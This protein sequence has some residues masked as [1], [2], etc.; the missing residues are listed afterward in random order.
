MKKYLLSIICTLLPI[1][2]SGADG[3]VLTATVDGIE[4][5]YKVLSESERTCQIGTSNFDDGPAI[6]RTTEGVV[7]IPSSINNY[8]VV[9]IGDYALAYTPISGCVITAG[10]RSIGR[11]I[12]SG[13]NDLVSITVDSQNLF[14][15]DWGS[16]IVVDQEN[17]VLAGCPI[18]VFPE[19]IV[20]L[21]DYAFNNIHMQQT[22]SFPTSL[23]SIG[24][25]CFIGSRGLENLVLPEGLEEIGSYGFM[26]SDIKTLLLP[27]TLKSIGS[28]CF[29][30]NDIQSV[31]IPT[32]S[33]SISDGIFANNHNLSSIVVEDGNPVY[34]S[35]DNCNAIVQMATGRLVQGCNTTVFP[36]G[37]KSLG[38]GAFQG[39]YDIT[40]MNIPKGVTDLGDYTFYYCYGLE[41]LFI[42][43]TV[44]ASGFHRV[45]FYDCTS[46]R[47]IYSYIRNPE[48]LSSEYAGPFGCNA[49]NNVSANQT[50]EQAV[51]YVPT[52]TKALYESTEGWN[53]FVHIE[54]FDAGP[55][56]D[57]Q[58]W[59]ELESTLQYAD[60][61]YARARDNSNVEQW[62]LEELSEFMNRGSDML[63]AHEA[64]EQEVR[65]MIE[66][67]N[68]I[69]WEI[70]E[71]MNREPEPSE[72]PVPYAI[73]IDNNTA[74]EFRYDDQR[75]AYPEAMDI[76]PFSSTVDRGWHDMAES[77]RSVVFNESFANCTSITSTEYWFFGC[78]NLETFIGLENLN[79]SN[80]TNMASMFH[81]C[82]SLTS[83]DLSSFNTTSVTE[84]KMMFY[85][86][87]NLTTIYVSSGWSTANV[88][89]SDYMFGGS[90]RIVGGRGTQWNPDYTD[91]AYAHIDGG[92]DNPG[93]LT[94]INGSGSSDLDQRK[95]ELLDKIDQLMQ[96]V[97]VCHSLLSQKDPQKNS[98]L[99]P[100]L[101]YIAASIYDVGDM[102]KS[103]ESDAELDECER[104]IEQIS[105]ELA[106][107]RMKIDEYE[108]GE[109][110]ARFDGLTAWVYGD[111][112]LDDA[113]E[114]VGRESAVQTIAA[115]VWEGTDALTAEQMQGI[116]NPNLLVY[117][118]EASKA[119][120]G[121]R[122]VIVNGTAANI[123]LSDASGNNNFFCPE[124][125]TAQSISYTRNFS[126][127]TEIGVSRGWETI[128]LPFTVQSI[129]H[130]SHGVLE[131]FGINNGYP[132][133]LRQLGSDGLARATVLE[134]NVPFLICMPNNSVYPSVYNQVG[135][136][137]FSS[138]NVTVPE[139]HPLEMFG[140][141]VI[142]TPAFQNLAAGSDIFTLNVG[143]A[144][145]SYPEGS[146][147]ISNYRSVRPFQCY[148]RHS[149]QA[150]GTDEIQYIPLTSIGG[151]DDTTAIME[152]IQPA[153]NGTGDWYSLDGRKLSAKPTQKGVY[154]QNGKKIVIK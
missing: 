153:A 48:P 16:N 149:S 65:H 137:T 58:Y 100:N 38:W 132:F 51:L 14:F 7:V 35:P 40:R 57:A 135:N 138:S 31:K 110:E 19:G 59:M 102:T 55:D 131:P 2:A 56:E 73:F 15:S 23:R 120:A 126:Q 69:C 136:V 66:E 81:G 147:F 114:E 28:W 125:F 117:V 96:E 141:N 39:M 70:E 34:S 77:V 8:Q 154:I 5:T 109:G 25:D 53:K 84:M 30:G 52:G 119:P 9:S 98:E 10:V 121:V 105:E 151:G 106:W 127:T 152:I 91:A 89:S 60:D 143:E 130:E 99:W 85:E 72:G 41:E 133:W 45:T 148:A 112:T 17:N 124:S 140:A 20:G 88:S 26:D 71:A 80:V 97:D 37:I 145:G 94:D 95:A 108:I 87:P 11:G 6:P 122:N 115:I 93:Y 21:G 13:C 150:R 86:C 49:N 4:W 63:D 43:S 123:T 116:T 118:T 104:M 134:A 113:F 36:E 42:P 44:T 27:S 111:A 47:A 22:P 54:E 78:S 32:S 75:S 79:T 18:S 3:D 139:T 144:Q 146:V 61:V 101:D 83:L 103:A 50:Y 90:E 1:F 128:A 46:L 74:L 142:L 33:I 12:F 29:E 64:D 129:T 24:G 107:L 82:S 68:W 76:Y 62:M 92:I 67:I